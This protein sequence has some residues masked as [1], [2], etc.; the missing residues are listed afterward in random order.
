MLQHVVMNRASPKPCLGVF[1]LTAARGSHF[2]D[3]HASL[4]T[5]RKP[6]PAL[7]DLSV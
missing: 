7:G 6:A 3:C 1:E 4:E 5:N 2:I